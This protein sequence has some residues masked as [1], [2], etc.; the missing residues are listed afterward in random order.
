MSEFHSTISRRDFMKA[1]GLTGASIGVAS[2]ASPIFHDLDEVSSSASATWKR[3]W[4]VKQTDEPTMEV[5]WDKLERYDVR[6]SIAYHCLS[7]LLFYSNLVS[8]AMHWILHLTQL[9]L[10]NRKFSDRNLNCV[11]LGF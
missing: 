1:L 4:Y 3:P 5:D 8:Q 7:L 9:L 2:A 10:I 11:N 6:K